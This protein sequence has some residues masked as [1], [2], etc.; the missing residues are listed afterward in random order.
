MVAMPIVL[1][2]MWSLSSATVHF[3]HGVARPTS[4]G[5]TSP[6]SAQSW[7]SPRVMI[8]VVITHVYPPSMANGE[9]DGNARRTEQP[10][11]ST[12]SGS[13]TV[14]LA[15]QRFDSSG[16]GLQPDRRPFMSQ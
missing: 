8:D 7:S 14:V 1:L 13:P 16:G 12:T 4:S 5:A 11:G 15:R 6:R 9:S 10:L 3:E 2:T